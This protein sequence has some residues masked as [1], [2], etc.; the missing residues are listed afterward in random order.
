MLDHWI[1][2]REHLK[3]PPMNPYGISLEK[4]LFL[5]NM[6]QLGTKWNE[7]HACR[8][9]FGPSYLGSL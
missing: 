6:P 9:A 1:G 8:P 7:R 4:P 2:L 5:K 3:D